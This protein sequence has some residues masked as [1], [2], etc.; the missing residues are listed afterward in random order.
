[1][2]VGKHCKVKNQVTFR[3]LSEKLGTARVLLRATVNPFINPRWLQYLGAFLHRKWGDELISALRSPKRST[4]LGE[5][6]ADKIPFNSENDT[7]IAK[8]MSPTTAM[9]GWASGPFCGLAPRRPTVAASIRSF[10]EELASVAGSG[11]KQQHSWKE[12]ERGM[13]I[14]KLFIIVNNCYKLCILYSHNIS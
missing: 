13:L 3:N 9:W 2:D 6:T 14:Y 4:A 12:H 7:A 8:A 10:A 5:Q 1:M 11:L